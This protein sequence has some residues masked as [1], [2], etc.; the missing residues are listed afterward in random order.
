VLTT[1]VV[2]L[3]ATG[4]LAAFFASSERAILARSAERRDAVAR[5]VEA[6]TEAELGVAVTAVGDVERELRLGSLAADDADAME[7]RLFSLLIDHPTLSDV[8]MTHAGAGGFAWQTSVFRATADQSSEIWTRR[9]RHEGGALVAEV[10]RRPREAGLLAVPFER[11]PG[12]PDDPTI[13]AT[14]EVPVEPANRGRLLWSDL[15]YSE[16]DAAR[17]QAERRVVLSLQE[18]VEDQHGGLSGVLRAALFART[19]DSIPRLGA[20]DVDPGGPAQVFLCDASGRLLTRQHPTDAIELSGDD[21]R[22]PLS[23]ASAEVGVALERR[24]S[25]KREALDGW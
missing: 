13:H 3:A 23:Q 5:R 10:R 17:S 11:E 25:W 6:R 18:T 12:V 21:L 14:Y 15:A 9:I 22:V 7:A 8:T 20:E 4:T 2:A 24:G 1:L 16:L 19:I